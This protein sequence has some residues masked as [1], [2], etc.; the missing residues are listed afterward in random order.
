VGDPSHPGR[1]GALR[2]TGGVGDGR[3]AHPSR[4][5][6]HRRADAGAGALAFA[7]PLRA[8]GTEPALAVGHLHLPPAQARAPVRGSVHGRPLALPG[9]LRAGAPPEVEPGPRGL[10]ARGRLVRGAGGG[11][12]RPGSAVHRLARADGLRGDAASARHPARQE[13]AAAPGDARQDRALLEDAL[14]GALVSDRL[15]RLR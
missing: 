13:P 12:D 3:P 8:G 9:R 1:A 2:G 10:R 7:A 15:R 6:S 5:G 14:A 11:L 4:G